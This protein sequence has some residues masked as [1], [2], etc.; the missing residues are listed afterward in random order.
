MKRL[1]CVLIALLAPA[2]HAADWPQLLGPDRDGKSAEK[3]LIDSFGKKGPE[4]AWD[5][6]VGEGYSAPVIAGGKLLLFH[7]VENEDVLECLDARTGKFVWKHAYKTNYRDLLRKGN[8]PRATPVVDG[9]RVFT[10]G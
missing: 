4:V 5:H 7:R 1:A 2:A 8:G 3:G 10:L 6:E 9:D